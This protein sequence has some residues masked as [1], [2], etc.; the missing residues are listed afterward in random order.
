MNLNNFCLF[1]IPKKGKKVVWEI[2]SKC[3]MFC[4]HCC[5][6]ALSK[7]NFN[8]WVFSNE[9]LIK[10]RLNEMI[11]FG[12]KE[13]Y[14]SGGEP[15]LVENIF[16]IIN[17]LKR[18]K[19]IVSI[20]T[21]GYCLNEKAI[22]KF[23]KYGVN[24]LHIS[25]DGHLSEIHNALR[26][27]NFFERIVKNLA[28]VKKY[29]IPLRIGCIIWRENENF[30]EEMVK[31]CLNLEIKE[32]RFSWLIKVG[33]F[34]QYPETYPKRKW[35]AVMRE[36]KILKEKY[37]NKIVI[38]I[39][40]NP[41]IKTVTNHQCPG[42]EKLFFLNSQG[43]LS[44]CSWIAKIDS[45]FITKSSLTKKTFKELINSRPILDFRQ[46]VK[47]RQ[48][49]KLKGCPFISKNQSGSCFCEEANYHL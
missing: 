18:K 49:R 24:L 25:L 23:S 48:K 44:P 12:I 22:K 17:F 31:F 16:D 1:T 32:L 20:A 43:K 27:G 37:K 42:G 9:K 36:I 14:I 34:K 7:I 3:N 11:S 13:F 10:R 21:N 45:N 28:I 47:E 40:R 41:F 4:R 33:R 2:T 38:S 26:R 6:N 19:A 5:A 39:H 46:L 15:L 35:I 8:E 29:K 30:L